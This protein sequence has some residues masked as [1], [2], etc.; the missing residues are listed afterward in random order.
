MSLGTMQCR[1]ASV[2]MCVDCRK[3]ML[4]IFSHDLV[5][6][7]IISFFSASER[8]FFKKKTVHILYERFLIRDCSPLVNYKT[9]LFIR[10]TFCKRSK[11]YFNLT[12]SSIQSEDPINLLQ[13][14]TKR[15]ENIEIRKLHP[16]Q[17]SSFNIC[18]R[19]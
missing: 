18:T 10:R 17:L 11:S 7:K 16:I 14:D 8:D 9:F 13:K 12:F 4:F 1:C 19:I 3:R 15:M 6:A 5:I 2:F